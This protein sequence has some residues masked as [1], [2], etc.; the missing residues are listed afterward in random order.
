MSWFEIDI[1]KSSPVVDNPNNPVRR[2]TSHLEHPFVVSL[3][4]CYLNQFISA[5]EE[6]QGKN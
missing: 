3:P 2:E 1:Q 6:I 5:E 4:F